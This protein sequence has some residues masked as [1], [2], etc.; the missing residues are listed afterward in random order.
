MSVF[1]LVVFTVIVINQSVQVIQLARGVHPLL[2]EAVLWGL[3]FLYSGLVLTPAVL[4]LRL[5]KRLQPPARTD[6]SEYATFLSGV[7]KRLCRNSRLSGQELST[8]G[9]IQ[10]ALHT[11]DGET[12]RVVSDTASTVFLSTAV[13]QS[14]RPDGSRRSRCPE[15]PRLAGRAH[16]PTEAVPAPISPTLRKRAV[17][18]LRCRG[19]R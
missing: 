16:L 6:G 15:P 3:A 9:D 12:D 8:E 2:G 11:L 4:W 14:G 19:N 5:P 7:R 13:S 1:V 17:D 18:R 10:A